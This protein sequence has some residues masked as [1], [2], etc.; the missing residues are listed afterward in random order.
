MNKQQERIG[1][2]YARVSTREQGEENFSVETQHA[3]N[4]R[5]AEQQGIRIVTDITD[6]MSGA[7]FERP[8][9]TEAQELL[10]KGVA[11]TLIVYCS[12]RFSRDLVHSALLR[13]AIWRAGAELHYSTR[14]IVRAN[15]DDEMIENMM[16]VFAQR[17]RSVFRERITRGTRAKIE[18]GHIPGDGRP[19]FGYRYVEDGPKTGRYEIVE[20][21]A[22]IVRLLYSWYLDGI[23]VSTIIQKLREQRIPRPAD[24]KGKN[25]T[26]QGYAQWTRGS[27][28]KLLRNPVYSGTYYAYR[29]QADPVRGRKY[30][31]TSPRDRWIPISVPATISP[32]TWAAVQH[33]LDN[34]LKLSPRNS[35]RFYLLGRRL[36]CGVCG[37]AV[38]GSTGGKDQRWYRCTHRYDKGLHQPCTLPQYKSDDLEAIVWNWLASLLLDPMALEQGI[39]DLQNERERQHATVEQQRAVLVQQRGHVDE[40]LRRLLDLYLSGSFDRQILGERKADLEEAKQRLDAELAALDQLPPTKLD[41]AQVT[42]ILEIVAK[43]RERIHEATDAKKRQ[44]IDLFD[45][46]VTLYVENGARMCAVRCVLALE[47]TCLPMSITIPS[48][49]VSSQRLRSSPGHS[50]R[51]LRCC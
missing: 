40:Q 1:I 30:K 24:V 39:A 35:K 23:G 32:E 29:L 50:D 41:E 37:R 13:Q 22:A 17:E 42:Q 15:P 5:Y 28:Y 21:D 12:D 34:G 7:I 48:G 14:G 9:I 27:V 44:L 10:A 43:L 46:Q 4:H 47:P 33:K 11:N 45:V 38:T 49:F 16:A 25:I 8:G 31:Q 2:S 19:P 6:M 36:K 3:A 51:R 18:Q 26:K 20:A